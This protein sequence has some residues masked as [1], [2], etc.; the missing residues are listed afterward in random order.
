M[1]RF[2][3][4][5]KMDPDEQIEG[6]KEV[7]A[8][9]KRKPDRLDHEH[10]EMNGYEPLY[11]LRKSHKIGDAQA[12]LTAPKEKRKGLIISVLSAK[13]NKKKMSQE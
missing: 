7:T 6:R 1:R 5:G 2:K 10:E 13:K 12:P 4:R 3:N 8:A 11:V 9:E